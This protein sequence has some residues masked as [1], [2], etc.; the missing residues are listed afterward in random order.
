MAKLKANDWGALSQTMATHRAQLLLSLLPNALAFGLSEVHPEPVPLKNFDTDVTMAQPDSAALF[1]LASGGDR[2]AGREQALASLRGSWEMTNPRQSMPDDT[3][4]SAL[5]KHLEIISEMRV[6]HVQEWVDSNLSRF[7][8]GQ[9]NIQELRRTLQ[10]ATTDLA[11]NI[12]LCATKCASCHLSCVQSRSHKGRHDCC[13]SH[14]CISTCEFCN[15]AE[16]KGCTML[17]GHSG[18]HICAVTAHL[19][20]EPCKLTDKVGCL[21]EC[22]KMVGHA[23]DDHMCSASVHMCGEPCELKKM[24]LTDGSSLSCPGTCRIPSDKLHGQ[25]LCDERRCPAKCEL[26]KHL[27]S[28]QDHLHGLESG[29]VHLC[30]QEHTCAALCAAQGICEIAT[31]PQSIEATFTGKHETFEYTKYSQAA[32]RLKCIKPISPGETQHSGAHSHSM[33]KQPFHFC[34]NKCENCGYFCTLPLGHSQMLHDTSHGSMSQ[35]RWAVEGPVDSTLELEGRKFSSNDDGAPMMCNLVCQ[36]MGRHVHVEYC[37]AVS[38]SSCVGSAVQHIPSRMVPEPDRKKDFVTHSLYWERAGFKDPYSRE[39]QANFA[40]C[41]AMCSGPEHKSTSG[42]P[43]QPSYCVLPMFH[44]AL[45]SN[46]AVQ[47]L[48]YVSQ[49]GHHFSCK[50][51]AVMQQAFHVIFAIDRSGSMSL[52]DRHPLPNTPVTNL[53]AGRSNNRLGAVLSSLHSFWSSRHAAVTAGAQN[54][55]RR[56]SYSVILFD[57]TM[58]NPLTHDF[59][60]SPDQ[61]LAALLP[62]GAAGGTDYTS[63]IQNAQ[64]VMER[65]WSTERSPIIIFLSDGECSISDQTMQNLCRAAVQRGRALSFHA[66]SFGPDRAA[67]SLRRMAQIAQDAQTNAPRDPLMPAE[68]IVKSSYSEALDSVRLAETFLGIA[69]SLKKPRGSLFTMKP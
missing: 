64:A 62:Y 4:V 55:N 11:A 19:C 67:P 35:T 69:D 16:L 54:A 13:T 48:G 39:D 1:S 15:S 10:S 37:R 30:G 27:C 9:E 47:G 8:T 21:T 2:G 34:E 38:G 58:I 26:C 25:H 6:R 22:I 41:D 32:K 12:Q 20:G 60:S 49:D 33:D 29:A 3:W 65:N 56:D 40:K 44:A 51:P 42:G 63:A 28:A 24:K 36:S 43:S 5:S 50:N 23:D 18:K 46:S 14:R 59:S 45:N 66:V 31:A 61:L 17:A 57:H 68:A 52:G 53:I 7:Q